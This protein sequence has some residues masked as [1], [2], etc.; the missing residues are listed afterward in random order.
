MSIEEKVSVKDSGEQPDGCLFDLA[1][2]EVYQAD[3]VTQTSGGLL[4]HRFTL[5]RKTGR[6]IFC[7]TISRITPGGCYPPSCSWE[8][9]RSSALLT[10]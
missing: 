9:G 7:G 8:P 4:H 2:D 1:P 3:L 6:S 5:T 10:Q